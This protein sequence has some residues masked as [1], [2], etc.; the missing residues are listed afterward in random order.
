MRYNPFIG[1]RNVK[2]F[3]I[4]PA[5]FGACISY[6]HLSEPIINA[7]IIFSF[8]S[9]CMLLYYSSFFLRVSSDDIKRVITLAISKFAFLASMHFL[10]S[11]AEGAAPD[12]YAESFRFDDVGVEFCSCC[13]PP[14]SMS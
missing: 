14:R 10:L 3:L 1:W 13:R 2:I 9:R 7:F 6:R 5:N 11:A 12:N 4:I 8:Q